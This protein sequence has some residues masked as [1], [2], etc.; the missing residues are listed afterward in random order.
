[1]SLIL[2]VGLRVQAHPT[3]YEGGL[4]LKS[5]FREDMSETS[6]TYTFHPRL[7]AGAEV[8][9]LMLPAGD[10]TWYFADFNALLKRWNGEESQGNIYLLTGVGGYSNK[11]DREGAGKAGVQ[12]DYETRRIYLWAEYLRW[13]SESIETDMYIARVG[14]APFLAGYNDLNVWVILQAD[15]NRDM[16]AYTQVTPMLRFYYKNILWE[17][18]SSVRGNFY[19]QFMVHL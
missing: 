12:V 19:G 1:M 11:N 13:F 16:R 6:V 8:D 5:M 15:Y 9:R 10:T 3:T 4:M 18:G 2:V 17:I 14:Y 7:A